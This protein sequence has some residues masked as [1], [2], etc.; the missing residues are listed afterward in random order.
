MN[1]TYY[2]YHCLGM[3]DHPNPTDQPFG[4]ICSDCFDSFHDTDDLLDSLSDVL[5][6]E[7][8]KEKYASESCSVFGFRFD[9]LVT[10]WYL[11]E[12]VLADL[13]SRTKE[14][15]NAD[16]YEHAKK[17]YLKTIAE[18]TIEHLYRAG[19]PADYPDNGFAFDRAIHDLDTKHTVDDWEQDDWD[20]FNS[21]LREL[22]EGSKQ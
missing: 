5:S 2:C 7:I 10:G 11:S 1:N 12:S 22:I 8:R 13:Y 6:R 16:H 3:I 14:K 17:R 20:Q 21:I 18:L 19:Y 4:V 15:M 9:A